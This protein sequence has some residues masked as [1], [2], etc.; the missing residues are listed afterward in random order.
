MYTKFSSYSESTQIE[1]EP[2]RAVLLFR[3]G[4]QV[5]LIVALRLGKLVLSTKNKPFVNLIVSR[6]AR[7][8]IARDTKTRKNV[9]NEHKMYQMVIKYP[10][11]Q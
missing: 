8:Y 2:L 7:F 4:P 10:K 9:P 3:I 1:V 6:V 11:C 5:G